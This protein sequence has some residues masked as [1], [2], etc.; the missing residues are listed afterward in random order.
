[1]KNLVLLF[2]LMMSSIVS[3]TG[4][5]FNDYLV[6]AN[7]CFKRGEY[8]CA[9][10]NYKSYQ[11]AAAE[12]GQDV[13]NQISNSEKCKEAKFQADNLYKIKNYEKAVEQYQI[14]NRLNPNDS[15]ATGKYDICMEEIKKRDRVIGGR[16][17]SF[18]IMAGIVSTNFSTNASG[19]YI[20]SAIDYG[21]G[22]EKPS[23]TSEIGFSAG[24]LLDIR[25]YNNLYLQPGVNY[26]NTK[27]KN[28][29]SHSFTDQFDYTSTT[30][31]KGIAND[32]FSE[33]YELNYIEVPLL[34]SY[35]FKLS[36]K[37]NFQINAGPYVGYGITGKC[38]V[39]GTTDWPSLDEYYKSNNNPTG[40][41]YL[42][43]CNYDG[44]L[45]LFDKAKYDYEG[46]ACVGIST[47][48]YTTGDQNVYDYGFVSKDSPFQRF[49]AGVSFGAGFEFSGFNIRVSYDLGLMNIANDGYWNT[50][51]MNITLYDAAEMKDYQHKLNKLQVK[52]GYIFRW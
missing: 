12:S 37:T 14:I 30:Y 17:V 46:H 16:N 8:D 21:Y 11:I 52:V 32:E 4:Q 48:S 51:R 9:I 43:N 20:G 19:D 2:V 39:I 6:K 7:E 22:S 25:L 5:D 3:V 29:F 13:N 44:E 41:N 27:I 26:V 49:N 35:R 10:D 36:E 34:L 1:M 47:I 50:D 38:K 23:Y 15:Y 40:N 33:H 45:N 18:G 24:L 31:L 28:F 42:M